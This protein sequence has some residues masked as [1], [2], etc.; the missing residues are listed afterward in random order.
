MGVPGS[1]AIAEVITRGASISAIAQLARDA[2]VVGEYS[3][4]SLDRI[5]LNGVLQDL[6]VLDEIT[7][8]EGAMLWPYLQ[9]NLFTKQSLTPAEVELMEIYPP[10]W[11]E[12]VRAGY[13]V[14]RGGLGE[15][16]RARD[17]STLFDDLE[18][19][20]FLDWAHANTIGNKKLAEIVGQDI[21]N[22]EGWSGS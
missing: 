21:A 17:I 14:L 6:R 11:P 22:S 3:D 12:V 9:P 19:S 2:L 1:R 20:P 5:R 18:Q 10:H 15:I 7:R 8:S 16:P 13:E 4:K